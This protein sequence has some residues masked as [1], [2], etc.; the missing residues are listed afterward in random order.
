[1]AG[2]NN[3]ASQLFNLFK[4]NFS[5]VK[6]KL[7]LI[8]G[9]V[10]LFPVALYVIF[11][12]KLDT[13]RDIQK[14]E[15]N[16]LEPLQKNAYTIKQGTL[17]II[18]LLNQ[19]V[20][21]GGLESD[22]WSQTIAQEITTPLDSLQAQIQLWQQAEA[23]LILTSLKLSI[24][25]YNKLAEEALFLN[26]QATQALAASN[27]ADILFK[28]AHEKLQKKINQEIHP[29][30]R[31]I[32][33]QLQD[34][35][36]LAH[37]NKRF[38]QQ[39]IDQQINYFKI[40]ILSLFISGGMTVFFLIYSLTKTLVGQRVALQMQL[41][42][43]QASQ[44]EI[45][46]SQQRLKEKEA[47]LR[48][49]INNINNGILA[50]DTDFKIT[51][52]NDIIKDQFAAK[53]IR[54]GTGNDVAIVLKNNSA[55]WKA[56]LKKALAGESFMC[57][58]QYKQE[59]FD[60][61]IETHYNPIRNEMGKVI[62]VA[63]LMQD[64]SE[65]KCKENEIRLLL[66]KADIDNQQMLAQESIMLDT[67]KEMQHN[68]EQLQHKEANLSAVINNTDDK[69]VA[70]D[71]NYKIIVINTALKEQCTRHGIHLDVGSDYRVVFAGENEQKW[72][73]NFE[74][75]FAGE[76]F[77]LSQESSILEDDGVVEVS[78]NPIKNNR[79]K[80]SGVCVFIHD[81]TSQVKAEQEKQI[82]YLE[83]RENAEELQAQQE[84]LRQNL[85]ELM[86]T[87][88]ELE[89][90]QKTLQ[91]KE[92]RL[93][94]LINNT[95]DAI[96]SIDKQYSVTVLN[97]EMKQLYEDR[98]SS[99]RE[100]DNFLKHLPSDK[101]KIW[102]E[103]FQRAF[104]DEHFTSIWEDTTSEGLIYHELS[105]N[106]V[107]TDLDEIIGVS[108]FIKDITERKKQELEKLFLLK[109]AENKEEEMMS[110]QE[111]LRDNLQE[112]MIVRDELE[113]KEAQLSSQISAIN[114]SNNILEFDLDGNIIDANES[115][116]TLTHYTREEITGKNYAL[117]IPEEEL[118]LPENVELWQKLKKGEFYTGEFKRLTKEANFLWL[119][120]TYNP[121]LN[122]QGKP[123][124]IIKFA[125]DITDRVLDGIEKKKLYEKISK[126][127]EELRMQEEELRQNLEELKVTQEALVH[128]KEH[129]QEKEARLRALID[130]TED[131]IFAI[132]THYKII[133]LN[134]SVQA[135]YAKQGL[136]LQLGYNI[137][138]IVP[139][140]NTA[141]WKVNFDKA[142]GGEKFSIVDQVA[143]KDGDVYFDVSF[144]PIRNDKNQV[145]GVSVLSRNI[146]QYKMAEKENLQTIDI[147][148]KIQEK[149]ASMN[150]DKEK[151]IDSYKKKVEKLRNEMN[152]KIKL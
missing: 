46:Q 79:G 45:L 32:E 71:N 137:F 52:V 38:E 12:S 118:E 17:H 41:Q 145:I 99:L 120:A 135:R 37:N 151:E 100:G 124:K 104:H 60:I 16:T 87:Q 82:L 61:F 141:Y 116:L 109:E 72:K 121:V 139:E 128:Q 114:K 59:E 42:K 6:A 1:M 143:T 95:A 14:F 74:K 106:P 19:S 40:I 68:Q 48:S 50:I 133:V 132:D 144:N 76:K 94:A 54:V 69:I 134:K 22:T 126:D 70:I 4:L 93:R 27:Y 97:H 8:V 77:I 91:Q 148:R 49:V 15:F 146:N 39:T 18:S 57:S 80:V 90:T 25:H 78:F 58:T 111:M 96:F 55:D 140:S 150:N 63:I 44:E 115:F 131:D 147:L 43:L 73:S 92:A 33:S 5:L 56:P 129:I 89:K 105:F 36:A 2:M 122:A 123:Y 35:I 88:E 64:V 13:V 117:F 62:G 125:Y 21:E 7:F 30:A 51:V 113:T 130:N 110:Q 149:V 26:T 67:L 101:K 127:A 138:S 9:C 3:I 108:V 10:F 31:E 65:R 28:T 103:H 20:Y 98:F 84:E 29:A 102:E 112:L 24:Y 119:K 66:E 81:I 23:S 86:S 152:G 11:S 53:G 142:I 75:A 83:T 85:E 136:S 107:K 34:L 47:G